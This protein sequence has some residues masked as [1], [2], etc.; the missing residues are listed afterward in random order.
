MRFTIS[1]TSVYG[2][3]PCEDAHKIETFRRDERRFSTPDELPDNCSKLWYKDGSNHRVENGHIVRDLP[4]TQW[5]I[6]TINTLDDL[7][8]FVKTHDDIVLSDDGIEIYD[9][10]RE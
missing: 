1:R 2:E 6:D 9:D 4:I 10:Y 5:V 3:K 8:E 7:M